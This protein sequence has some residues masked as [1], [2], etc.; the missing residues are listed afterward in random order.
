VTLPEGLPRAFASESPLGNLVADLVRQAGHAQ[1][2]LVNGG[3]LRANLPLGPLTYGALF[4]ALPFDNKLATVELEG[5]ALRKMLRRNLESDR[6][7]LSISGARVS[8]RCGKDGLAVQLL[9]DDGKPLDDS[10]RYRVATSDFLA[11][12][13]DD[14]GQL[15]PPPAPQI[16]DELLLRDLVAAELGRLARGGILRADD[17]RFWDPAHRRMDLPTPRPVRCH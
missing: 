8:A 10:R 17:P 1:L 3:G 16:D 9:F 14:F 15:S 6:G 13:G 12:G 5:A 11:L 2:G 4:E 7:I